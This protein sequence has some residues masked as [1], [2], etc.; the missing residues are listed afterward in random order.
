MGL[1]DYIEHNDKEYQTKNFDC[2]MEHYKIENGRLMSQESIDLN[3]HGYV[4]FRGVGEMY[5]AK[6]TDGRLMEVVKVD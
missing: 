6:F 4:H 3:Y 1:Y 5:R 2:Q